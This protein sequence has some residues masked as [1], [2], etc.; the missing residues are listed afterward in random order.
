MCYNRCYDL[1]M[2]SMNLSDIAILNVRRSAYSC[3]IHG[4]RKSEAIKLF[5]NIKGVVPWKTDFT[6]FHSQQ[7]FSVLVYFSF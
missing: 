5:Q 6:F 3:I 2:M 4:I 7:L 1:L